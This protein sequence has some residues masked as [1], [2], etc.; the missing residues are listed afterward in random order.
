M[1]IPPRLHPQL[2]RSQLSD[3]V[4]DVIKRRMEEMELS[5]PHR[6]ASRL[7]ATVIHDSA[8]S[9]EQRKPVLG[10]LS[11]RMAGMRVEPVLERIDRRHPWEE[12]DD[13][14]EQ[15]A[16]GSGSIGRIVKNLEMIASQ[17]FH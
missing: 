14:F 15:C 16:L 1:R 13:P 5:L 7:V 12:A 8:K 3:S 4:F 2:Q 6:L 10:A 17:K 9:V 11:A